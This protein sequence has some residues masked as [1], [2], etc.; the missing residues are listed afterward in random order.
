MKNKQDQSKLLI[1]TTPMCQEILLLLGISDFRITKNQDYNKADFAVVLSETKNLKNSTTKF[2]KLKL[3]TFSQIEQ[4]IKNIAKILN[5]ETRSSKLN[6][7]L[8]YCYLNAS[9][10]QSKRNENKKIK[11][12]V[13]SN[14]LK[15]IVEDM[16]YLIITDD[17]DDYLVYPDYLKNEI[18]EI[19]FA[20]ERAIELPSHKNAPLNPIKRAKLRY[21]IL[22]KN[23]CMKH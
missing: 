16:G 8:K 9:Y 10:S 12:K 18:K 11:V 19:N 15:D 22:E 2:I 1:V 7:Q 23:L 13:Y 17:N 6:E 5:T 21:K 4:S 14:F 3:N 20:G